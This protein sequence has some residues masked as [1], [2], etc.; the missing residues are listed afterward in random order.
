MILNRPFEH[1]HAG[2]EAASILLV[3]KASLG[4]ID[5]KHAGNADQSGHTAVYQ[6]GRQT[7]AN[8]EK[9]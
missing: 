5:G 6:L 7:E 9:R 1:S 8:K 3:L 2:I 4:Q